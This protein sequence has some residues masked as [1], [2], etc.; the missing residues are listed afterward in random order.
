MN[1]K[2]LE[3]EI[4]PH[5]RSNDSVYLKTLVINSIITIVIHE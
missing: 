3:L 5:S 4:T 1:T 2:K